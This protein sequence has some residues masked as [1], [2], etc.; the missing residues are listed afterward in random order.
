MNRDIV[1]NYENM[2]EFI[3]SFDAITERFFFSDGKKAD[4]ALVSALYDYYIKKSVSE[5]YD[6]E[7]M[8]DTFRTIDNVYSMDENVEE[9]YCNIVYK[10]KE[11][12]LDEYVGIPGLS[13]LYSASY[14]TFE[15]MM[16]LEYDSKKHTSS[17]YRDHYIHQ[18]RNLYEM[19]VLL[20]DLG[21]WKKCEGFYLFGQG[22]I[23][24]R[25]RE[26]IEEETYNMNQCE[27]GLISKV[28]EAGGADKLEDI[29][30]RYI[31]FSVAFVSALVHDIG[32]PIS[33]VRR[34]A[35]RLNTFLPLSHLFLQDRIDTRRIV[36]LLES[37]LLFQT[38]TQEEIIER[39]SDND[40]GALSA[41]ILLEKYYDN[42]RIVGLKPSQRA[43]IELS[44]LVIYNHTLKYG[45]LGQKKSDRY[46]MLYNKN[47][48]S[49]LFRLCDDLQEWDRVYFEI[50]K[51]SNLFI[52]DSCKMPSMRTKKDNGIREYGCLCDDA[53][54]CNTTKF[55][56]RKTINIMAGLE[57]R[58]VCNEKGELARILVKY[59]KAKLLEVVNYNANYA[60]KRAEGLIECKKMLDNQPD[61]PV[62]YLDSF[63]SNN[64]VAI[65]MEILKC[66]MECQYNTTWHRSIWG[67][68]SALILTS[69]K[70]QED[71]SLLADWIGVLDSARLSVMLSDKVMNIPVSGSYA[72]QV[73]N[74]WNESL[75]FYWMLNR[76]SAF[77]AERRTYI[78]QKYI[79]GDNIS[80]ALDVFFGQLTNAVCDNW[81][82]QDYNLKILISDALLQNFCRMDNVADH[83]AGELYWYYL[84]QREDIV[85]VVTDYVK[86]N[87]YK[88]VLDDL[89]SKSGTEDNYFDY[90]SDYYL[91]WSLNNE[92]K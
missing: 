60:V 49:Y 77:L 25:I 35:S 16:H 76:L 72:G 20:E 54:G 47:P 87:N 51:S 52:C 41:V 2:K 62:L 86:V 84:L 79:K 19:Y 73:R 28:I 70:L 7:Q 27:S 58:F 9:E 4:P 36:S 67:S 14:F 75:K 50:T 1:I 68:T 46:R 37:S 22:K 21:Y 81:K 63:I 11:K 26:A 66:F 38:V 90:Y 56:Y 18:V 32:Y 31:M 74:R 3:N 33:Y 5:Q 8:V 42:G 61:F 89:R 85:D 23:S 13:T 65:K 48:M 71:V 92:I 45:V 15:W 30:F 78:Y 53:K 40:H 44:A 59:D 64:P 55:I 34:E 57:L 88:K 82:I 29:L 24:Q 10:A 69:G 80:E 17:Y 83:D 91:F 6:V 12:F 39:L 43:V